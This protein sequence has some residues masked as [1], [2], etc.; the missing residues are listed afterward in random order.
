MWRRIPGRS[1]SRLGGCGSGIRL[2]GRGT[3]PLEDRTGALETWRGSE[4]V[5]PAVSIGTR[6]T[7]GGR[8]AVAELGSHRRSG[9]DVRPGHRRGRFRRR[10]QCGIP[11]SH[12]PKGV[13]PGIGQRHAPAPFPAPDPHMGFEALVR[14]SCG[15]A[16]GLAQGCPRAIGRCGIHLYLPPSR[17]G[18]VLRASV[19]T[20]TGRSRIFLF[21]ADLTAI[22]NGNEPFGTCPVLPLTPNEGSLIS[23]VFMITF[24][25]LAARGSSP[26]LPRFQPHQE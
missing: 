10:L 14:R 26:G 4:A 5:D 1:R 17:G 24:D 9:G 15:S 3:H 2:P 21:R 23:K 22:H 13:Q 18:F 11:P 20:E 6:R 8:P 7:L 19:N 12:S 16:D 25:L